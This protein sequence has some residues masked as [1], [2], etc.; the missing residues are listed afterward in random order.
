[1][2]AV[3]SAFSDLRRSHSE[4]TD[5]PDVSTRGE[6]TVCGAGDFRT[7]LWKPQIENGNCT[8]RD[9]TQQLFLR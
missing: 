5:I 3:S 1:M 2:L 7:A 4:F 6:H 9:A 8:N